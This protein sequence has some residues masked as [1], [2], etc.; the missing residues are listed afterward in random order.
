MAN[1]QPQLLA[2]PPWYA[3]PQQAEQVLEELAIELYPWLLAI[4]MT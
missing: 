1:Q 4:A 2:L 3:N